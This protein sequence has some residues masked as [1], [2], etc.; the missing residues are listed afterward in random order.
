[1]PMKNCFRLPLLFCGMGMAMVFGTGV[2]L[3][4]AQTQ[5]RLADKQTALRFTNPTAITNGYLPLAH[6]HQDILEG[7]EDG[8]SVRVERAMKPGTRAFLIDGQKVE[9]RIMEDREFIGGKL[10]EV[11]LDYFAQ[12]EDGSVCYLGEKVD[13][14]RDGKVIGHE[15]AWLVGEHS[16]KPG[17]IM[18]AHPK[19]GDKFRSE[20]V[21]GI[22]VEDDEVVSVEETVTVPSGA[23]KH[24][25]KIK[26]VV[27][28]EA[29]EYKY[30]APG[31]GVVRELPSGGDVRLVKHQAEGVKNSGGL[32]SP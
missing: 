21:P 14:Y 18:P 27:G 7:K 29:P 16:A 23:Y 2:R 3:L 30:Y 17:V 12:A 26:E 20:N 25:V 5:P 31:I 9:A 32:N 13:M 15:G 4:R 6:L 24:C 11:T 22:A 10:K 19:V 28:G 8:K 1:M